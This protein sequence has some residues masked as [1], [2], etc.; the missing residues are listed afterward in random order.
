[1]AN[2]AGRS[3]LIIGA[4]RQGL[5]LARYLVT[6]GARVTLN[7]QRPAEKMTDAIKVL[8]GLPV[9]WVLG[10]HPISLLDGIDIVCLSGGIPLNNPLVVEANRR[11]LPLSNDSQFFMELV[12]CPVIGVTGSAGKTT[13]TTL[14]GRMADA[15]THAPKKSWLGGNIGLPLIEYVDQMRPDDVAVVELSSFQLEQM[16]ISPWVA[17]VLNVT[18]NHLDRHGTMEAYTAAKARILKFQKAADVAVLNREDPGSWGLRDI[19]AGKLIS[20]G[21]GR[22][23]AGATG[24][25]MDGTCLS[26]Q[27]GAT[28]V[29]LMDRSTILLPGEHNLLNVLAACAIAHA[30]GIPVEAMQAAVDGFT[31]VAHRLEWVRNLHGADWYN[32]SIATAPERTMAALRS[33]SAPVV[34]LLGGRDKNLPWEDLAN[35]VHQRVDHL[36]VFGEAVSKILGA[37]GETQEGQRPFTVARTATLHEAVQVAAAVAGNGD[38]VLLSP[39][40]TSFDEFIDFEERGE[41]YR[42][43]VNELD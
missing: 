15:A 18:P 29:Q 1:M 31:G 4:A 40:G 6:H 9:T 2:Y 11:G 35:M 43:W 19:T 3:I 21:M 12:P 10:E 7:D 17:A 22:P 16:T 36:V 28:I 27:D 5:A 30:A 26:L 37:I 20:F 34:L 13:T 23:A 8:D 24:T 32:D 14:V 33:F 42:Q 39:G 25:Y 41:R 38:V